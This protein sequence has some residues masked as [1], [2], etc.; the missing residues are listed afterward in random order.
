MKTERDINDPFKAWCILQV[1]D[2]K[3]ISYDATKKSNYLFDLIVVDTH[4]L[5]IS[6]NRGF[7]RVQMNVHVLSVN[8]KPPMFLNGDE[9]SFYVLD[10]AKNGT[11]V[12]TVLATDMENQNPEK[13]IYKLNSTNSSVIGVSGKFELVTNRQSNFH[14][15]T[16]QLVTK[17][18]LDTKESPYTLIVT[19]YDGPVNAGTTRSS[20]KKIKVHVM[21]K[22]SVSVWVDKNTGESIDYYMVNILIE[23]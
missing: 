16:V 2:D 12:G 8:N 5:P 4:K 13:L 19:A 11:V 20:Q 6:P 23:I 14:W 15:G 18:K 7:S 3:Y 1:Q 17:G 10:S 21:N 22:G 9:E